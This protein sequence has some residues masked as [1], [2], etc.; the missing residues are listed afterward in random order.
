MVKFN[1][2]DFKF[3]E[4][5][6]KYKIFHELMQIRIKEILLVSSA[7]DNFILEE[8][9]R[10]SDQIYEEFH[11]LNLRT[12]PHITRVS[13][14]SEALKM[15]K[16]KKF[17]LVVTMRRLYGMNPY[18]FGKKVKEIK[19]LPVIMLLTSVGDINYI[20]DFRGGKD[21]IDLVFLWNG[22]STIFVSLTKLLE[23]KANVDNDTK[24][25]LVRVIIIVEDSIKFYSLYLPLIYSEIM[26]QTHR[27]IH[28]GVN[29]FYRL[30]QMK[31]RPK[32]L[33]AQT[34]E[35]AIEYYQKY[36]N[37]VI[38]IVS[39]IRFQRDGIL[40]DEAG[41]KLINEIKSKEPTI[42]IILQS[43]D[44]RNMAKA[45]EIG[46]QF[47]NKNSRTLLK[48]IRRYMLRYMGFGDFIFRTPEGEKVGRAANLKQFLKEIETIPSNSLEY[49]A[50]HDN[51]SGWLM[52]RGEFTMASKLKPFKI[53]D[54]MS[55]EDLRKF[56]RISVNEL[57]AEQK[58]DVTDFN[59][60]IFDKDSTFIRLR[61]G[62]LGGKGRGIAF[63]MFILSSFNLTSK[64][65]SVDV[66]I[67]QT[68]VIGTDEFDR[69][70]EENELYDKA[71]NADSTNEEINKEFL[72]AKLSKSL[73]KDLSLIFKDVKY[74]LAIRSSSILEDSQFQPY[75]GVFATFMVP[76]N[77]KSLKKRIN[78]ICCAIKM[79]YASTFSKNAKSYSET[80]NQRIDEAK[81]AIVIQKVVGNT[82]RDQYF[83]PTFSG[84]ALSDNFYP[85]PRKGVKSSD[86]ISFLALGLGKT[87]VDGGIT[88]RFCPVYPEANIYSNPEEIYNNSQ[89]KYFAIDL[90]RKDDDCLESE[91]TNLVKLNLSDA[92][93]DGVLSFVA[94]T[95]DYNDNSIKPSYWDEKATPVITFSKTLKYDKNF[96]IAKIVNEILKLGEKAMGCPVEIEFAGNFRKTSK[97]KHEFYLL[98]IRPSAEDPEIELEHL[99]IQKED[100]FVYSTFFSG[101]MLIKN[102]YDVIYVKPE[103]FTNIKTLDMVEE[104]NKLNDKALKANI[105]YILIGFGRW[106]T[107][108]KHLGIPVK[109]NDISGAKVIIET[110]LKDFSIEHSQGSHFFQNITQAQ[111]GYLFVKYGSS[112]DF[113]N[114]DWLQKLQMEEETTYFKHVRSERPLITKLDGKNKIAVISKSSL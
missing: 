105:P 106:G 7:Y 36:R 100:Q 104:I 54:F 77:E 74:P 55:T 103:A 12:L 47:I 91:E 46:A 2:K 109:W 90:S 111:I 4:Y 58:N 110:G 26:K 19:N 64:I 98:Q 79:V 59:R 9:G 87:I 45:E 94:D 85:I 10:L 114:W 63:L 113:I 25:G 14:A 13:T 65:N 44:S 71:L 15:L 27:L 68:I 31:A 62:S 24:N 97:E 69:F 48:E 67:P 17:D 108:D 42:P 34:Y 70:M 51:F 75:A 49:H 50:S 95:Y 81:M 1:E 33:L 6:P 60:E 66:R 83:Y 107:F 16:L 43:S 30:L 39:D 96:Q 18:D 35:E 89:K 37:N 38:G 78:M 56:L 8:D 20:P 72:N 52:A 88:K 23:D 3:L 82:Y 5:K 101:N 21:G 80:I 22:D 28:E 32:I 57:L 11:E 99:D 84:T 73:C 41:F 93:D 76:N 86:G 102:I 40:D 112:I 53:S 92:R 61:P 29:D